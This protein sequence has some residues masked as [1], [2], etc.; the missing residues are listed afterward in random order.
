M[1]PLHARNSEVPLRRVH[2]RSP[3]CGHIQDFLP[4]Y[5]Q[6]QGGGAVL[7]ERDHRRESVHVRETARFYYV[8]EANLVTKALG[9][10]ELKIEFR[11]YHTRPGLSENSRW[12]GVENLVTTLRN[13]AG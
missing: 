13:R 6:A 10:A 8:R 5:Q 12:E 1:R 11:D 4:E 2:T 7:A 3:L 9:S